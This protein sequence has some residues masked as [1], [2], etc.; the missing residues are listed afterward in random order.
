MSYN[1]ERIGQGR[2]N[3]KAFLKEHP[4]ICREI[5]AAIRANAGLIVDKMLSEPEADAD[6]EVPDA[7][8][9]LPEVEDTRRRASRRSVRAIWFPV[10]RVRHPVAWR[11]GAPAGPGR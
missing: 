9:V 10:C 11:A 7:D 8:G 5:E 6:G 1:G 2:E 3:T 4:K